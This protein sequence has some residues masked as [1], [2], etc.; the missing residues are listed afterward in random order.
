MMDVIL[1]CDRTHHQVWLTCRVLLVLG[2]EM[3]L[4]G[5]LGLSVEVLALGFVVEDAAWLEEPYRIIHVVLHLQ[6]VCL[7]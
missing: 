2:L 5:E 3:K 4:V 6:L 7:V 1:V